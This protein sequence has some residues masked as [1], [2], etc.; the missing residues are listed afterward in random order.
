MGE[1]RLELAWHDR[2]KKPWLLAGGLDADNV[3]WRSPKPRA[4]V[5][6]SPGRKRQWEKGSDKIAAFVAAA[7]RADANLDEPRGAVTPAASS[8][9]CQS[10]W[11]TDLS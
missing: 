11:K 7:R 5:D 1:L 8:S 4:R 9:A 3:A 2:N 6:V 10:S